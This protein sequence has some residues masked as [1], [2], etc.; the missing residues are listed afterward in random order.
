MLR[1][2]IDTG[3]TFSDFWVVESDPNDPKSFSIPSR[4]IV[5]KTPS[6]PDKPDSAVIRGI[7]EIAQ[8]LNLSSKELLNET[9]TIV[10]GTTIA[11][12]AVLT[13][14]G[15][16]TGLITT[17]GFRD[18]L[19][20]RRGWREEFYNN[21]T[22]LPA[23]LIRRSLRRTVSGRIDENGQEIEPLDEESVQK[24]TL[25]LKEAGCTS[26]V[27]CFM[28]SWAN[29]E[30]EKR[31]AKIVRKVFPEAFL[32][33]SSDLLPQ[34]RLFERVSTCA[35][36]SYV[37]P[38]IKAHMENLESTL[39]GM[40]FSGG[41]YVMGSHGGVMTA[42]A[43]AERAA[44]VLLS[45]PAAGPIAASRVTTPYGV[46]DYIVSDMGGTSYDVALIHEGKPLVTQESWLSRRRIALPSLDIHTL[47][48]GG[49]SIAWVDDGGILHVGPQSAGARPGPACYGLGGES[50]TVTD[51]C[52]VLGYLDP[53]FFLGG[54][55]KLDPRS[56]GKSIR[57]RIAELMDLSIE[58]S[59]LGIYQLICVNMA[60]GT[61][62]V[63]VRRGHDPRDFLLVSAGGA[64]PLHANLIAQELEIPL[65][66]VP[67]ESAI[68]CAEGML[69]SDLKHEIAVSWRAGQ[70]EITGD[71]LSKRVYNL[72]E[73][74]ARVLEV[75]GVRPRDMD[76]EPAMDLRYIGQYHEVTVPFLKDEMAQPDVVRLLDRFHDTHDFLYGY[77]T[78][79]MPVECIALRMRG[80]GRTEKPR[81]DRLPLEGNDPSPARRGS[82]SI[83]IPGIKNSLDADVYLGSALRPGSRLAGPAIIERANT[84]LLIL[85]GYEFACDSFGQY[86]IWD[87]VVTSEVENALFGIANEHREGKFDF[88]GHIRRASGKD[89]T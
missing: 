41:L 36:N 56:A 63:T 60:A 75:Q 11:T 31:A 13:E 65:I 37:G 16:P 29:S 10:Y 64:G 59:A 12:N 7:A 3:G 48:A 9:E 55:M 24:E 76:F 44:S 81:L 39:R 47:G 23:P 30:H 62:E 68:F 2:G 14:A 82:R 27:V 72:R 15:A 4:G 32:T 40:G 35:F 86:L 25:F 17:K 38:I 54:R 51:A 89:R 5:Y 79:D 57:H 88:L 70:E 33:I 74:C 49:G 43:A 67:S 1:I 52:L 77:A 18:I 66:L 73:R 8:S 58:E 21:K 61:R 42:S 34:V 53:N 22:V 78:P 28:H 20:M 85:P 83:Y 80:I 6:T 45:G 87:E 84:T 69:L 50:P 71:E 19:Q 26:L 46:S